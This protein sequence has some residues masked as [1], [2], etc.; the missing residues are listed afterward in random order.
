MIQSHMIFFEH[1]ARA[2]GSLLRPTRSIS[3][4]IVVVWLAFMQPGMSYYGLIDPAAHAQI[5][6]ELYGQRPDGETLPGHEPHPP[7]EHPIN[8]GI[9]VPTVTLA[10]PFDAAF[11]RTLLFPAQRLA[12]SSHRLELDV[13]AQAITLELPDQPPRP[14]I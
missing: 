12:L 3:C 9:S 13:I 6:A 14:A 10:N 11:Y 2:I 8:P 7:H 1:P 4:L 5:D